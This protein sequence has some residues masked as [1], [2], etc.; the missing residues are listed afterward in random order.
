MALSRRIARPMLASI[1]IAGGLEALSNPE[2]KVKAAEVVVGPIRERVS[3]IPDD[4]E[5][6]VRLNGAVQVVSGCLLAVGRFRRLASVALICSIIPTTYAGHRFWEEAD[7]TTRTQQ[8]MHFF[9]NLG[10]LGGL[11]LAALDTE[12]EPS[13]SWRAK[14]R[15]HQLEAA[16][17]MGR[18]ATTSSSHRAASKAAKAGK[19]QARRAKG[20]GHLAQDRAADAL[21]RAATSEIPRQISEGAASLATAAGAT[22]INVARQLKPVIEAVA[23]SGLDVTKPLMASGTDVAGEIISNI[24]DRLPAR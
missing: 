24:S 13:L 15:G 1:F 4:P 12:G 10:L 21:H 17:A 23:D 19:R 11:I 8:R 20:T 18:A 5:T 22:G 14:R 2:G 6:L 3:S 7:D 16:L 9:K